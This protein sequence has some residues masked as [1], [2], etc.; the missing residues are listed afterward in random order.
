M[1][2]PTLWRASLHA[3]DR[4]RVEFDEQQHIESAGRH[5]AGQRVPAAP[6]PGRTVGCATGRSHGGAE[7]EQMIEG[8]LTDISAE[9]AAEAVAD[10]LTDVYRLSCG[11]CRHTWASERVERCPRCSSQNV[12]GVSL[13]STLR[14]LAASRQHVEGLLDGIQKHL[15]ALGTNLSSTITLSS[16][17]RRPG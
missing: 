14:E 4:E 6:S 7:G 3:D 5:R 13:N 2:D 15:E 1:A 17:E 9:R 10:G 16:G 8:I 12:D 11:D